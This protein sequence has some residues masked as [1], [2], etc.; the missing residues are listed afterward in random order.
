MPY[1]SI[2]PEYK[3]MPLYTEIKKEK[4]IIENSFLKLS[5]LNTERRLSIVERKLNDLITKNN[6][7]RK[8]K[9]L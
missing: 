2:P 9:T 4:P 5:K 7:T 3:Y 6:K 8:V 1:Y